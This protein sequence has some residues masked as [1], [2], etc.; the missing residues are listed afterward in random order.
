[1]ARWSR[2]LL[3]AALALLAA[4]PAGCGL[5]NRT[6]G[7]EGPC[8]VTGYDVLAVPGE[9]VQVKA[10]LCV[11]DFLDDP[12]G[13]AVR[14]QRDGRTVAEV[15]TDHEGYAAF[16]FTPEAPGDYV[17]TASP[18]SAAPGDPPAV[19]QVLVTCRRPDAPLLVVD[20]DKTVVASGFKSVLWGE[21]TP[22]PGSQG[23]LARL[24]RDF[25]VVYLTFRVDYLGPKTRAW[26]S[27]HD[28]PGGPVLL[29][30]VRSLTG[31]SGTYKSAVLE[32]L[33][34]RFRGPAAGIGDKPSDMAAYAAHGVRPVLM[35]PLGPAADA[36]R[37][38]RAADSLRDVA[39]AVQVV[40]DWSQAEAAVSGRASYPCREVERQW[41]DRAAALR[42]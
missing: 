31:D 7:R 37:L 18:A 15:L 33:R 38:L 40:T 29:A 25:T 12:P 36:H 16:A 5:V 11:G 4:G 42:S 10:R 20:L 1:M 2:C 26:L 41:R 3:V 30:G 19:A 6:L 21:P 14:F 17:F 24:D 13:V 32:E 22:M 23:A 8:Q 27:R 34:Q 39:D 9:M 35:L 28:Y